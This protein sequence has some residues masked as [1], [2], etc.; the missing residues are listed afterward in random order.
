M[1]R[2]WCILQFLLGYFVVNWGPQW[3]HPIGYELDFFFISAN[4]SASCKLPHSRLLILDKPRSSWDRKNNDIPRCLVGNLF[5]S[6]CLTDCWTLS[7]FGLDRIGSRDLWG[8]IVKTV[9]WD[10]V[11]GPQFAN[12]YSEYSTS[13][14]CLMPQWTSL[15]DDINRER[16]WK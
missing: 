1:V 13:S 7:S 9:L 5:G 3:R 4:T 11:A 15:V 2:P 8:T 12:K 6:F 10:I 14:F 16:L